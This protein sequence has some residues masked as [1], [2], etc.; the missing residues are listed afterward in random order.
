MSKVD[1]SDY[2]FFSSPSVGPAAKV[3]VGG[4]GK[5]YFS[6]FI[7]IEDCQ[8]E[9]RYGGEKTEGPGKKAVLCREEDFSASGSKTRSGRRILGIC[10]FPWC[11]RTGI[12][13]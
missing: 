4:Y 8:R 2:Y 12:L 11:R 7:Q 5:A 6:K 3:F 10:T 13:D 9:D 1:S